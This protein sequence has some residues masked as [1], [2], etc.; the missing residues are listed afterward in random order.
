[1]LHSPQQ[2]S[3]KLIRC[4]CLE[5]VISTGKETNRNRTEITT[6]QRR[7]GFR[8]IIYDGYLNDGNIF[9]KVV[10]EHFK[11]KKQSSGSVHRFNCCRHQ[12]SRVSF[13]VLTML[14]SA[15]NRGLQ[16]LYIHRKSRRDFGF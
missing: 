13:D 12:L 10:E 8:N 15:F 4:D 14:V 7:S 2:G 16:D 5:Y 6:K 11:Y 9:L 1:M 3:S